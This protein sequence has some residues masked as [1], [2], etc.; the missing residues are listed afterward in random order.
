MLVGLIRTCLQAAVHDP[1][2]LNPTID[3]Q[4]KGFLPAEYELLSAVNSSTET[5]QTLVKK[6]NEEIEKNR[7]LSEG[8]LKRQGASHYDIHVLLEGLDQSGEEVFK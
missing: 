3:P 8:I 2:I 6:A 1:S 7:R 5:L 4:L